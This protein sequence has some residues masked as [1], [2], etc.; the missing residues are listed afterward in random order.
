MILAL[1]LVSALHSNKLES[2]GFLRPTEPDGELFNKNYL[3]LAN[4]MSNIT[5]FDGL[6]E[7]KA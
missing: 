7:A 1:S 2:K 3:V 6:Y 5:L 4:P